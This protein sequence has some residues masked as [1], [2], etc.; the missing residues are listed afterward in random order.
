MDL[1]NPADVQIYV[2]G[3]L[4]LDATAFNIDASAA[5]WKLLAHIE[6]SSSTDAYDFDLEW[7]RVRFAE[8]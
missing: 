8:Q 5:T 6:K 2:D 4:V 1:R 7:L 3:V